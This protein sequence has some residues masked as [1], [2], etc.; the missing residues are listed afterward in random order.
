[1][2]I[3]RWSRV[4]GCA[5]CLLAIASFAWCDEE[6][7]KQRALAKLQ[8]EVEGKLRAA[9]KVK[10]GKK[11]PSDVFLVGKVEIALADRSANVAFDIIEGQEQAVSQIVDY[12]ANAP[13]QTARNWQ[14]LARYRDT[15]SAT[16]GLMAA[17]SRYDQ[18]V[19][20]REQLMKMYNAAKMCRT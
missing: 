19:A 3:Y 18:L 17:R 6:K 12:L 5:A 4:L 20:Y 11:S 14:V 16:E 8:K 13:S 2:A 10:G 15:E 9:K 1:M 7:D